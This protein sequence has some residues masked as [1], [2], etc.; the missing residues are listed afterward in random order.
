MY[1][2]VSVII[3][4]NNGV[5]DG[6]SDFPRGNFWASGQ[7]RYFG[8]FV[9][10]KFL[11]DYFDLDSVAELSQYYTKA[12]QNIFQK[13]CANMSMLKGRR[14]AGYIPLAPTLRRN[15]GRGSD[16]GQRN[17]YF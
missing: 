5:E 2:A 1:S 4:K 10:L 13:G 3:G 12:L 11:L 6:N 8:T 9:Q 14:P 15:S 16:L 7:S 17:S